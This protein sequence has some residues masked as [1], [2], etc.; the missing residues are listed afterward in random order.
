MTFSAQTYAKTAGVLLL[1]SLVAGGYGEFYVPSTLVVSGG[2]AAT[3]QNILTNET[4]FRMG[5]AAYLIEAICDISLA[6]VLYVLL[7]PVDRNLALLGAFFRLVSTATFAFAEFFYM[8][9]LLILRGSG[10]Y[11][12]SFTPDQL[13][14][15]AL[16]S[17]K[18]YG[19]G[20]NWLM[21]FYGIGSIVFGWLIVRSGYLPKTLGILL[22]VSGVGFLIH[23]FAV[24]LV[25]A[26]A[27]PF[28]LLPMM[29]TMLLLAVWLLVRGIDVRKW[30]AVA[31]HEQPL[32]ATVPA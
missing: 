8:A 1:I 20:G 18:F 31:Q 25:P 17:M 15:L 5:F 32:R 26:Y 24:V 3:A 13:N 14:A 16:L 11:L 19:N 10:T 12:K 9:A 22:A 28:L 2:P 27:S 30:D 21:V 7:K 4:T 29:L 6:L 23:N